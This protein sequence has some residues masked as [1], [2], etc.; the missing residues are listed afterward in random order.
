MDDKLEYLTEF[1]KKVDMRFFEAQF[2]YE[3]YMSIITSG[4]LT[5]KNY[6]YRGL[7][8]KTDEEDKQVILGRIPEVK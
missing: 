3:H 4:I 6:F 5:D 8:Q 2:L 7:T 1:D